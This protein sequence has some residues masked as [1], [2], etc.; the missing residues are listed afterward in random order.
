M[1]HPQLQSIVSKYDEDTQQEIW[2]AL[3]Q[4]KI[5]L[6]TPPN[7]QAM[8]IIQ[9]AI[10]HYRNQERNALRI[11]SRN[12]ESWND[13]SEIGEENDLRKQNLPSSNIPSGKV[14]IYMISTVY[15]WHIGETSNWELCKKEHITK[16]K[17]YNQLLGI[18]NMNVKF[19]ILE[20]LP[21]DM[22]RY[23]RNIKKNDWIR[24]KNK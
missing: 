17:M 19:E 13:L 20:I 15:F 10:R 2:L 21:D 1:I 4:N 5:S 8:V 12:I 16:M 11:G 3:L 9:D 24:K 23:R 14:V 7:E 22:T 18:S 6:E